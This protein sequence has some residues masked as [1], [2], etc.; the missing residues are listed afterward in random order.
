M[1]ARAPFLLEL[2]VGG[3]EMGLFYDILQVNQKKVYDILFTIFIATE[4][5]VYSKISCK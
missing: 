1:I 2:G 4:A 3:E 5:W